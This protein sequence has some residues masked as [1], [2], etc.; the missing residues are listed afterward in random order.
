MLHMYIYI[1]IYIHIMCVYNV[2][3]YTC[4]DIGA[5]PEAGIPPPS[6]DEEA[7]RVA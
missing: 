1:Y 6:H 7:P 2:T 3:M 4:V 5:Q